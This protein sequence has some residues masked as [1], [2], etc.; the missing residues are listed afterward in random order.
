MGSLTMPYAGNMVKRRNPTSQFV[1][2]QLRPDVECTASDSEP[3]DKVSVKN[4]V[5]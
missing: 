4:V 3:M 2:A 5:A 1:S